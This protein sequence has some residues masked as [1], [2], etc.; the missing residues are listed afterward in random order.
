MYQE[1]KP[2]I[3]NGWYDAAISALE[4]IVD[5]YPDKAIAYQELGALYYKQ[6][7]TDN[8]LSS[9]RQAMQLEPENIAAQKNLADFYYAE[10]GQADEALKIYENILTVAPDD[11]QTLILAGHINVSM[12]RFEAAR[13]KYQ[14]VLT[15]ESWNAEARQYLEALQKHGAGE[16]RTKSAATLYQ[17]IEPLIS[18]NQTDAAVYGLE[19]LLANYPDFALAHNDLGVLY[20]RQGD[21]TA[22]Q[23]HYEHAVRYEPD[24]MIFQKNLAD[25]YFVELNRIQE[26]MDIY[27]KILETNPE[28][29]E[30]LLTAGH[31]SVA[32]Q[33]FDDARDIYNRVLEI[34]PWN[35]DARQFLDAM[36][37]AKTL[38]PDNTPAPPADNGPP[39]STPER[40]ALEMYQEIQPLL[41]SGNSDAAMEALQELL[42]AHPNF[43]LAHNDMGVLCYRQ[44]N[45]ETAQSHYEHANRLQPD[46]IT[47]QKNLADFY[48]VEC[49]RVQE[50]MDIYVKILESHPEDIE[51]LMTAGH[52]SAALQRFDD[53]RTIYERVLE[54]EPWNADARQSLD[55]LDDPQKGRNPGKSI[56][57]G[58]FSSIQDGSIS[59]VS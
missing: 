32:L 54:I 4:K 44:G 9:Y 8:A 28:D 30:T 14:R 37:N 35:A 5:N 19:E 2:L 10:L 11:V 41:N 50:A 52:I 45:K 56:S 38:S 43:A 51:T 21:K 16:T 24:N 15:I 36:D 49:N 53:A 55:N 57:G 6:G 40:T 13:E 33:R 29:V 1:I 22:A 39:V 42:S 7:Q 23:L 58:Y 20:F 46:N 59:P 26:A 47:F 17:E 25:F 31:I 34:E 18:S 48:F 27:V 3:E 12:N